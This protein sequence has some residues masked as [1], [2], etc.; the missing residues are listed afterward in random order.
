MAEDK[1]A[2][3]KPKDINLSDLSKDER[4]KLVQRLLKFVER[5]PDGHWIWKG[6]T[7]GGGYGKFK[8]NDRIIKAPRLSWELFVGPIES[9]KFILHL[10]SCHIRRCICPF[11]LYEGTYK[12]NM[13]D[14]VDIGN[15]GT[16]LPGTEN[17]RAKLNDGKVKEIQR[18]CKN[19]ENQR[20]LAKEFNV[21][22]TLISMIHLRKIWKHI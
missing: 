20:A 22:Q 13:Q 4:I 21:T 8:F 16:S 3:M 7:D 6:G 10:N 1:R 9:G 12:E 14:R 19:G 18:R 11:H 2:D 15:A 5:T 17:G